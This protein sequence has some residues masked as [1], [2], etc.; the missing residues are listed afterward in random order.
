LVVK[1]AVSA[2]A[3][4][5]ERADPILGGAGPVVAGSLIV[6]ALLLLGPEERRRAKAPFW[7]LI[8]SLFFIGL[9]AFVP[10]NH[11]A[12]RPVR[13]LALT[14]GLTSTARSVFLLFVYSFWTRKV[15]R[16]L[17]RILRDVL[18]GFIF[19][20]ALLLV[21]R[22]AGVEP[23]SLLATS[24]LLTAVLGLS[25]QDT[26]GNLFAGLA[27]QAQR[28]FAVGDWVQLDSQTGLIGRVIEINWRATR[29]F[30]LEQVEVTI[31]NGLVAKSPIVNFSRPTDVVRREAEVFAPYDASPELVRRVL[32][33]GLN[34]VHEVLRDPLPQVFTRGFT[35]RGVSYVVRYCIDQ[36]HH[37]EIIDSA[38]RER[39]W[40]AMERAQLTMPVPRRQLEIVE[41]TTA[42]EAHAQLDEW[43]TKL[44]SEVPLFKHLPK[45]GAAHLAARCRRER[46][47]PEEMIVHKGDDSTEMYVVA[48]G[49]VRIQLLNEEGQGPIVATLGPGEFFGEM[50]LMTGEQRAADVISYEETSLL[51]IDRDALVPLMEK[52]S[53]LLEN[54]SRVLAERQLRLAE[55]NNLSVEERRDSVHNEHEILG[56]IRRF[57]AL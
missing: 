49:R 38:V 55:L 32:L 39:I 56:R 31:P 27:I 8:A 51:V 33:G 35:E 24:A 12:E 16:P 14:L 4:A 15:A 2:I 5:V 6:A 45:E 21:L 48:S 25:L 7:L 11:P 20:L 37:R 41:R 43:V 26:L 23:G 50:S 29:V 40:Y 57:F 52:H 18:Q 19:L 30:T 34:H 13:L 42:A 53:D 54:M 46:Y 9:L 22:S 36:F 47:G 17:P 3:N 10:P 44:I 28:P 1:D